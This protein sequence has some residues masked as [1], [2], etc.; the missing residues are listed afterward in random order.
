MDDTVYLGGATLIVNT[1]PHEV[2][3]SMKETHPTSMCA[4]PRFWE[5]VYTGVKEKIDS[6]NPI[7]RKLFKHALAVGRKHNIEYLSRGKRPPLALHME[8]EMYNK[9]LFS[10]VRH[11]LGLEH[12]NIF[13]TAGATVS[14]HVEEFVHS[15]GLTMVVA[16]D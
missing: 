11:E 14:S 12:T 1:D 13:P 10:L 8:Y 6:A 4:V 9:T 7:Q 5:K 15:I 16:T 2:Q 3:K